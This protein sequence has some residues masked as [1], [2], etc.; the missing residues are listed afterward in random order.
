[1]VVVIRGIGD[2]GRTAREHDRAGAGAYFVATAVAGVLGLLFRPA[3]ALV[4]TR[5]GWLAVVLAGLV[6][7]AILVYVAILVV[8]GITASFWSAFWRRG[9]LPALAVPPPG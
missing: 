1:M 2:R 8:P 5:L 9:S 4:A 3:V 6:G 7:Q